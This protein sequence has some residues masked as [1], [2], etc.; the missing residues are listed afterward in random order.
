MM[1]FLGRFI[2]KLL[3]YAHR[4]IY[5]LLIYGV[6]M[7]MSV[8]MARA[9]FFYPAKTIHMVLCTNTSGKAKHKYF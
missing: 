6:L 8:Y 7:G 2:R 3:Y 5:Y 4:N 1:G 9:E